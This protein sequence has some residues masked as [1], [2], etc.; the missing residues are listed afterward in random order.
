MKGLGTRAYNILFHTHTVTGIVISAILFVIFFAGAI[1]LYKQELYQ[2]EDP[3]ARIPV[4]DSIN[5]E[6]L[7][8]GL[9]SMKTGVKEANEI[10][11]RLPSDACPVYTVYVP[12]EDSGGVY[13]ST[14]TYNPVTDNITEL[15][16]GDGTTT[17]ETLYRLHFLDQ[18]PWYIGRYVAGFVS[19][20]FAFT[21]VAGLLIHW[22]NIVSKFY[23]FSFKKITKQFWTN[24]HTV[25]G[26]IGLPFQLMYAVTGAFYLLSIFILA[27]A[28]V[29]LFKGDQEKLI[30]KIYPPEAFH[31]HDRNARAADHMPIAVALQKIRTDHA[32]YNVSYLEIINPG[33]ENAALGADLV[34]EQDFNREGVVVLDL[35]S[36]S[37]KLEIKPGEK[38]YVQSVLQGISKL[39]FATFGGWLLK[40][41]YFIL[42]LFTCFVIISGVLMWKEAR[43]KPGYSDKQRR[44]H[45]RVTMVYLAVCFSLFP[46]TALLFISEQLVPSGPGHAGYVN[47][48][49]FS[50][51]LLLAATGYFLKT[52]KRITVYCLVLGG[53][54][55]CCVPLANGISTGD[56]IWRSAASFPYVF[57]TDLVWLI[58]GLLFLVLAAVMRRRGAG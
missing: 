12:L 57:I 27:P 17:G 50:C 36:G 1:S 22:K 29:V 15:F 4:T 11:V 41:L 28:V 5:Y 9:D 45:H 58:T 13:Y 43:N 33:K 54:L 37:Y 34:N 53:V 47:T 55:A 31:K 32:G 46:A 42:S 18:V 2:W 10:R 52:E 16:H 6:R 48:L 24:A 7:I 49:F 39:H 30:T 44:F 19:V 3:A 38:N 35:R 8:S 26:M 20:F 56:W 51:W 21:V 23:A 40:T 25:F 14:F